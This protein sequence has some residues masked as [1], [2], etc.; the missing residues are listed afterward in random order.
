MTLL[1]NELTPES[2]EIMT[3]QL[4]HITY[5]G[6]KIDDLDTY[7]I[8]PDYLKVFFLQQN[9]L[10]A[11]HGGFHIRGCVL[12]P[13]WHS[14]RKVWFGDLKLSGLFDLVSPDDIPIAQD[15]FGDQ[16]L[17]RGNE[18]VRLMS[19]T[20]DLQFL[21]IGF[22]DFLVQVSTD[23]A[24][25]LFI[26]NINHFNL[27]QGQLLDVFPPFCINTGAEHSIKPIPFEERLHYLSNLS[28]Q[29]NNLPDGTIVEIR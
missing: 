2:T 21:K 12:T 25:T 9:G 26:P 18:V 1:Q 24:E 7:D 27:Q 4:Q 16:Y 13:D 23:P 11:F 20:G 6:L 5:T 3:V 19:E 17:L 15:C 8:L 29:I 22:N 28:R 10:I 14:L